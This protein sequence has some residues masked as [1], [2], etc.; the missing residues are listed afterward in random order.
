[1]T[2]TFV[3]LLLALIVIAIV[4]VILGALYQRPTQEV[5][6]VRTGLGKRRVAVDSGMIAI[7]YFHEISR[8]NM[9]TLRLEV[10]CANEAALITKDRLRADVGVEF[11]VSVDPAEAGIARAAQTLGDITFDGARLCNLFEGK[12][13]DSLRSVAATYDM[14]SLHENR[15]EFVSKVRQDLTENLSTNGLLLESVSLTSFDQTSFAKLDENNTFNAVGMRK[16]A[17]IVSKSKK[18]RAQIEADAEVSVHK[19]RMEAA[20]RKLEIDLEE[21]SAKISQSQALETIKAAQLAEIAE[22]KA[23]S[24]RTVSAA[25]IKMEEDIRT[26]DIAREKTIRAAEISNAQAIAIAEQDRVIA[27]A[28]KSEEETKALAAADIAKAEAVKS[29]EAIATARALAET[30]RKKD[31]ALLV[32]QQESEINSAKLISRARAEAEASTESAKTTLQNA[33]SEAEAAKL[34]LSILKDELSV[35]AAGQKALNEAE[36]LLNAEMTK[37]R[38]DLARLEALPKIVE[39]MVKPAEKIDSIRIHNIGGNFGGASGNSSGSSSKPP[40][41]QA[42]DS[43]LEM[44]LQLP[45]LNKIGQEIGL[46]I[47]KEMPSSQQGDSKKQPQNKN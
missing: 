24:E 41:N 4:V 45:A 7:P 8:V 30:Q 47:D 3:F 27:V 15:A 46:S 16:L 6:F 35:K 26:A 31:V 38:A 1:M 10:R 12:F 17:E 21:E 20:K 13:V 42:I 2:Q 33:Q 23:D 19:A 14:D 28:K 37:L 18:D 43:I 5:S 29:A 22:R 44:A 9:R 32:A 25:R 34:R 39:Q 40:V 11:Y 36:N